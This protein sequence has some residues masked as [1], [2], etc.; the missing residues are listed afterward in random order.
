VR[1]SGP[2]RRAQSDRRMGAAEHA[3]KT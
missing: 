2:L 3:R 1:A